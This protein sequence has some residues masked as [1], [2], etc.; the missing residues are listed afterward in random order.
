[1]E[2]KS[3]LIIGAGIAGL[4]AGCYAQMNGYRSH[5]FEMHDLPGGLCTAWERKQYVFDGC[6]HYLFGTTP[7]QPFYQLWEELGVARSWQIVHHDE[8]MRVVDTDGRTFIA[9]CDPDRLEEHMM[10]LSPTDSALIKAFAD[11]VRLFTRF[12]MSLMQQKPKDLMSLSDWLR[13]GG[14]MMPFALPLARWGM[15]SAQDFADRFRDSLLR[16]AIPLVFGWAEIPLMAGMSL[17]AYMHNR[18]AGF[19]LGGSL[20]FARSLERRYLELGGEI[21]YKSQVEKIL[22][23]E[24]CAVGVRLYNDEIHHADIIISAADGHAT[25]FDMLD[26]RFANRRIRRIYDGHLPIHSQFQVSLGVNRD[27]SNEPHWVTYLLEQPVLIGGEERHEFGVKHYCFDPSLAP[28]GKS[29][30]EVMLRSNYPYWQRIYGRRLYDSE[31]TQVSDLV[32]EQLERIYPRL[33]QDIEFVDEATPVSYERYTGNWLGSTTGWLLT[34]DTMMLMIRGMSKTLPGLKNFYM[35]GQW[36]EPGGTVPIVAMSG[37]NAIQMICH[38]DHRPF[39]V[40]E[41]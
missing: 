21:Q 13:L 5:I 18:N 1:M 27:L 22:V 14:H 6:I 28:P 8:L 41:F 33:S 36:V 10:G 24:D 40:P 7:G 20:E 12:D 3:I 30:V 38:A 9:Y 34:K 35:V 26:G 11:G 17:L 2:E 25:I 29:V 16:R 37:R 32:I 4:S 15:I 39:V 19:P 23:E 31:Q